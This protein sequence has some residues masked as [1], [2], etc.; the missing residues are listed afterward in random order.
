MVK[1]NTRKNKIKIGKE[2]GKKIIVHKIDHTNPEEF[3]KN[4]QSMNGTILFHHPGCIH[5]VMLRPKWEKMKKQLNHQNLQGMILE[6]DAD[7]L[8]KI[9]DPAAKPIG[10]PHIAN[11]INGKIVNTFKDEREVDKMLKFV[12]NN[13][14]T[15]IKKQKHVK[16]GKTRKRR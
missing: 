7:A 1:K 3:K 12:S 4:L 8:E 14:K 11:V 13:L 5:C 9:N 15:G 2:L 10:L 16:F 6:V